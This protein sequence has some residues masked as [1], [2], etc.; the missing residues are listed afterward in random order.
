M[1]GKSPPLSSELAAEIKFLW[2][3]TDMNQAQIAARLGGI[4][5]GRISEVVNGRRF[6]EVPPAGSSSHIS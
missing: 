6:P 2:E 5:Q 1:R 3:N 4:N